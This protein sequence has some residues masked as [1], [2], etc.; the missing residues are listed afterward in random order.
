MGSKRANELNKQL[1]IERRMLFSCTVMIGLSVIL[2]TVAICTDWWFV[3]SGGPN[4][5]YVNE[6]KRVF[7]HSHS[8][9]WRIC[10][11]SYGSTLHGSGPAREK[12]RYTCEVSG[13]C[14]QILKENMS[15][16]ISKK[17]IPYVTFHKNRSAVLE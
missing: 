9:I 15:L 7:R 12:S 10:R 5:I 6:T 11:T 1:L 3:I 17:K 16:N 4:G 14:F 8:G 13:N 2:W